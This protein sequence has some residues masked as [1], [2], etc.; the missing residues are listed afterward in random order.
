[1]KPA[2]VLGKLQGKLVVSC[3]APEGDVFR[4]AGC[5]ARFACAAVEGGA[6]GIRANGLEDVR[7]IRSALAVPII[8]IQ[9]SIGPDGRVLITPSFDAAKALVQAG[10][11]LIAVDCTERGQRW[12]ALD[13]VQRIRCELGVPVLADIANCDEA[14]AAARAGADAVLTTMRGYTP[15]TEHAPRFELEFVRALR[16]MLDIPVIAEGRIETPAEAREAVAAGAFA[17]I[18]GTSITRPVELTR[19]FAA[20]IEQEACGIE[21]AYVAAIDMGGTNTKSGLVSSGGQITCQRAVPTPTGGRAA[22][23]DHLVRVAETCMS[24][25]KQLGIRVAGLG[26]AT[27]GWVNPLSGEVVYATENLPG[28]TGAKIAQELRSAAGVP[29]A[30]ECDANALALAERRFGAGKGIG[31]FVCITLGTGV[32]GGCCVNGQLIR[33]ANFFANALGHIAIEPGGLPCTCGQRGCLEVYAN[34]AALLR[35]AAPGTYGSAEEVIAAAQAGDA[36]ARRAV[37][38]LAS[39]LARGC[40]SVVHLLDPEILILSGG[41]AQNNPLL[42]ECLQNELR[43]QTMVWDRR[44]LRVEVSGI[45]YYGGVF[46]AAAAALDLLSGT[47]ARPASRNARESA[48]AGSSAH[49]RVRRGKGTLV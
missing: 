21:A 38:V 44:R 32:G 5:M 25:A 13:R 26:V 11:D 18:V 12:G 10:A 6:A 3:Q 48:R 24:D 36:A 34:A 19:R 29:V 7:A 20:A 4:D 46:G 31:N 22:L 1:M 27:A 43:A 28:W 15:D 2:G 23:L 30:V 17:V 33:G 39:Y 35:Y 41:L 49:K 14:L 8:G 40:A 47:A 45:G 37:Q 42:I 16:S 9:K